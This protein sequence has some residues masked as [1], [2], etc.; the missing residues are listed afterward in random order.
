MMQSET[1]HGPAP[2]VTNIDTAT[3]ENNNYRTTL[4]TGKNLQLTLM[5]IEPGHDVGLE[6]HPDNDQFL[7]IE[8]GDITVQMGPD[9]DNLQTWQ[10]GA[11]SAVFVP[12]GT[13]HNI[14]NRGNTVLKIY[15]VYGPPHHPHG[16]IHKT[17]EEAEQKGD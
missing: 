12:A 11:D 4:W 5:S 6:V 15:T 2:F 7:R 1:D 9:K 13:W 14:I 8:Q 17:K 16:T 3:V 10:A